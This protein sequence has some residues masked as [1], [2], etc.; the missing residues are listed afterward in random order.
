[1]ALA[2]TTTGRVGVY[3]EEVKTNVRN[4]SYLTER[5]RQQ[6]EARNSGMYQTQNSK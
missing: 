4:W 1:L 2:T 6:K 5:I 3:D